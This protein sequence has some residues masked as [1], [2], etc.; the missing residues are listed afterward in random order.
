MNCTIL[1]VLR[2]TL[3][4]GMW[5]MKM[6]F[7]T[8]QYGN[9]FNALSKNTQLHKTFILCFFFNSSSCSSPFVFLLENELYYIDGINCYALCFSKPK[10]IVFFFSCRRMRGTQFQFSMVE[11]EIFHYR[12]AYTHIVNTSEHR[13]RMQWI[14]LQNRE[15]KAKLN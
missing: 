14:N 5:I 12:F 3:W 6:K 11:K 2:S 1:R 8:L 10:R 4:D 15:K 7:S 9:S 13:I